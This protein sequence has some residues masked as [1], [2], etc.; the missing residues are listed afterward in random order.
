MPV[1]RW[2]P[3]QGASI[4][5]SRVRKHAIVYRLYCVPQCT[6][7]LTVDTSLDEAT[8]G[9]APLV[10]PSG[11]TPRVSADLKEAYQALS[12]QWTPAAK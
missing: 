11:T 2:Y 5:H 6:A 8:R 4:K 10:L 1:P 3:R 7:K 12:K 9:L